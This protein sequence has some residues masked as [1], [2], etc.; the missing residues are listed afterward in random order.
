MSWLNDGRGTQKRREASSVFDRA[1]SG[2]DSA[3][4]G[5]RPARKIDLDECPPGYDPAVW[6]L[7][8]L[9]QQTAQRTIR[10]ET[11]DQRI[12]LA[13]GRPM[14]YAMLEQRCAPFRKW[15]ASRQE[16][17]Q[18]EHLRPFY[19]ARSVSTLRIAGSWQEVVAEAIEHH[20]RAYF[21][22]EYAADY[23]CNPEVF[24]SMIREIREKG[25]NWHLRQLA[26]A[27]EEQVNAD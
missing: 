13:H 24:R 26:D 9:F 8:L 12:I 2:Q 10:R 15:F 18:D 3:P 14:I 16:R 19:L 25:W 6:S 11:T 20:F 7:A 17:A 4:A 23:F 21:E 1:E 5:P 27:H 22:D